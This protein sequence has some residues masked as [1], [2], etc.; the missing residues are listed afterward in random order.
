MGSNARDGSSPSCATNFNDMAVFNEL[1]FQVP[2]KV[3]FEVFQNPDRGFGYSAGLD[4]EFLSELQIDI[5][6]LLIKWQKKK[7]MGTINIVFVSEGVGE[8]EKLTRRIEK[9]TYEK[10]KYWIKNSY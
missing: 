8:I 9:I 2:D 10:G 3:F 7:L 5:L 1:K 4:E 6:K